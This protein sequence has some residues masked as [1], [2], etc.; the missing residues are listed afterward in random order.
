MM[1]VTCS[2][3][4]NRLLSAT[5]AASLLVGA[6]AI[7]AAQT[8]VKQNFTTTAEEA[9]APLDGKSVVGFSQVRLMTNN[10]AKVGML[11][12]HGIKVVE[13][14]PLKVGRRAENADYL[15]VKARKSGHLL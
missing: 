7:C 8:V 9:I 3:L 15:D 6:P 5:A 12:A 10:P 1:P 2:T 11:E 13:R 14:V 4:R